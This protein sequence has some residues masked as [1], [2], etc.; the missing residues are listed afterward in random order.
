MADGS[1]V[2]SG[3][4]TMI[5]PEY[6]V[7]LV[8]LDTDLEVRDPFLFRSNFD[9]LP[10]S[11]GTLYLSDPLTGDGSLLEI[12][13]SG[14]DTLIGYSTNRR[15]VAVPEPSGVAVVSLLLS[16]CLLRNRRTDST[17]SCQASMVC[18]F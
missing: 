18:S 12:Y 4:L 14:T 10:P 3:E 9:G 8:G 1:R 2:L 17:R 6:R 15:L 7:R 11:P 16:L 5:V 13:L